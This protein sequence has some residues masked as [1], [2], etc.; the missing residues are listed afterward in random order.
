M[1]PS[2]GLRGAM[3]AAFALAVGALYVAPSLLIKSAIE[4]DGDGVYL[5][6]QQ[7]TPTQGDTA[8]WYVPF[9]HEVAEGHFP[10]VDLFAPEN[11][12]KPYLAPPGL[13]LIYGGAIALFGDPDTAYL[14]LLFVFPA[15]IFLSLYWL[16]R[17]F[18]EDW[19]GAMLFAATGAMTPVMIFYLERSAQLAPIAT[20]KNF[21]PLVR[22]PI[23][24]LYLS[25]INEPLLTLPFF[26]VAFG[27]L[28]QFW[29]EPSVRRGLWAGAAVGVLAYIY[30]HYF[31]FLAGLAGL[32]FLGELVFRR[33]DVRPWL[34]FIA[35][36]AIVLIPHGINAW[37]LLHLPGHEEILLRWA[38]A[39]TEYGRGFR[40]SVWRDYLLYAILGF[41]TWRSRKQLGRSAIFFGTALALMAILWNVQIVTGFNLMVDHWYKAF[42]VPLYTLA[43]LLISCCVVPVRNLWPGVLGQRRVWQG[44]IVLLLILLMSKRVINASFYLHPDAQTMKAFSFP[45]E[46]WQSWQWMQENIPRD[47]RVLSSSYITSVYLVGY[48]SAVPYLAFAEETFIP[49]RELEERFLQSEKLFRVP[50]DRVEML[51]HG[52]YRE[53]TLC[54]LRGGCDDEHTS[55]NFLKVPTMLF[56]QTFNPQQQFDQLLRPQRQIIPPAVIADLVERYRNLRV[57]WGDFPGSYVYYGHWER[58][59]SEVDLHQEPRLERVYG[60]DLVEIFRVR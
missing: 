60:N 20:L 5:L 13:F 46:V 36:A 57:A 21:L 1:H 51:L 38:G 14:V 17:K 37:R 3:V 55:R 44:M 33:R 59:I 47:A 24:L 56:G 41:L 18:F 7:V 29:R 32:L 28:Y 6:L 15:I 9:A 34:M 54:A 30:L 19:L 11:R 31:L 35:T 27:F 48:T 49:Q 23:P 58:E 8:I 43:A 50:A 10:P 12:G 22:T 45:A 40:I 4:R 52:K 2:V 16:A 42:G 53:P 25:R 26:I 39:A